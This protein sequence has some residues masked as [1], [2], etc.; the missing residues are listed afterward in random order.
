MS[1]HAPAG[2]HRLEEALA[3]VR[4][5]RV[6]LGTIVDSLGSGGWGLSLLLFGATGLIP[7]IAPVF[8]VALCVIAASMILGHGRPWLPERMRQWETERRGLNNGLRR[9]R[10]VLSRIERWLQPRGEAFL[11]G[12]MLRVA[13]IAALVNAVLVV[14]PV[15]FGNTAPAIATL[16]LALGLTMRDGYAVLVGMVLTA[17]ALLIDGLLLWTGYQAVT[18]LFGWLF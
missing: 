17:L 9:L 18:A 16:V 13:G 11:T 4:G 8:G 7:G 12:S 14:L 15:P 10:P 5:E 1:A 3:E 2:L 6:S